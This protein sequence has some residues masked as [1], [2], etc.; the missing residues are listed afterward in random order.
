MNYS[1]NR[2]CN[3]KLGNLEKIDDLRLIWKN[4]AYDFTPWLAE[5]ENMSI[6][7]E[8]IGIEISEIT[9]ESSVGGFSADIV[10]KETGT[11]R[12]IIIENQ[13]EE[14]DH[15]HLG[16]IITYASGR[17]AS[18]VI[19]IV[20]NAREEHRKAIEW[21]NTHMD[22][23]ID[24]FLIQIELW[25]IGDSDPAARFNIIEQPNNWAKEVKK[26]SQELT[27]TMAFKLEYWTAFSDYVFKDSEFSRLYNKRKPSTDHWY[28]VSC[29][30]AEY[31][32]SFLLNTVKN[33]ILVECYIHNNKDVFNHFYAHKDEI[34]SIIGCQLDWR[35]LPDRK[36][37][38]ILIEKAVN[39]KDRKQWND[40][41]DW[42]KEMGIKFY[43]AFK[44][45]E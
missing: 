36:A 27:D 42:F 16:K 10:A 9:T 14:S 20:K 19:W 25:K 44:S 17:D 11:D 34:E 38:R 29:G 18:I 21:L 33:V 37:S 13:L 30:S 2:K 1:I 3:I 39:L 45:V 7:G 31:N 5:E 22:G 28:S 41:F 24:F 23:S 32:F 40:Q 15:D 8:T 26:I 35:E 43:R 4:E 6:L 12:I